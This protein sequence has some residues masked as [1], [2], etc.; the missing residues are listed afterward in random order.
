MKDARVYT[1]D[2]KPAE[3][4]RLRRGEAIVVDGRRFDPA[5][6]APDDQEWENV[7]AAREYHERRVR[8]NNE[9]W[10]EEPRATIFAPV[11]Q[12]DARGTSMDLIRAL[13][14]MLEQNNARAKE[15][16]G[17]CVRPRS[18]ANPRAVAKVFLIWAGVVI[19]AAALW[20]LANAI[21]GGM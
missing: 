3:F 2:L 7:A 10:L 1:M 13:P 15:E 4:E 11:T 9:Q 5:E 17:Q 21:R 18:P 8:V 6:P 20:V 12:I 16:C 19:V 14:R